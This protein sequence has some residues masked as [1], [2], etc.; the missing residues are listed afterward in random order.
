MPRFSDLLWG[1]N[2]FGQPAFH[3]EEKAI[4]ILL[5]KEDG[6]IQITIINKIPKY[7]SCLLKMSII[8]NNLTSA[9]LHETKMKLGL[10]FLWLSVCW[11]VGLN[12]QFP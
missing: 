11:I 5:E 6:H 9:Q 7:L 12:M 8:I 3:D 2:F 1:N 4:Q 10:R